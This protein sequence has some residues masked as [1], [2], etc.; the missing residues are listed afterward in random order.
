MNTLWK[1]FY[2]Y[3]ITHAHS[4]DPKAIVMEGKPS[5]HVEHIGCPVAS[6]TTAEQMA[7]GAVVSGCSHS[8]S[9]PLLVPARKPGCYRFCALRSPPLQ[10]PVSIL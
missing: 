4:I 10:V 5:R 3:G 6:G 9:P 7:G 8:K 2:P 1:S